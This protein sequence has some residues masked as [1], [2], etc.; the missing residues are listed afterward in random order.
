MPYT[1]ALR[2]MVCQTGLK[3]QLF[4]VPKPLQCHFDHLDKDHE[5]EPMTYQLYKQNLLRYVS[6]GY[7]CKAMHSQIR[8]K[9]WLFGIE[10]FKEFSKHEVEVDPNLCTSMVRSKLSPSG[11]LHKTDG[12]VLQTQNTLDWKTPGWTADECCRWWVYEATNYFVIPV[13]VYS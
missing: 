12:G 13:S 7:L 10:H 5:V 3:G 8:L 9:T 2:P 11:P 1:E 6:S 4:E